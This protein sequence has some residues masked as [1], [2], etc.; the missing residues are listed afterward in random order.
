M[1]LGLINDF[2]YRWVADI[3]ITGE[4]HGKGGKYLLLPPGYKGEIPAG[5]FVVSR[6]PTVIGSCSAPSSL[7]VPPSLASNRSKNISRCI[8]WPMRR[9]RPR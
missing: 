6:A 4:D 9:T 5:Y 2:W 7:T 3:G 1:V 8:H